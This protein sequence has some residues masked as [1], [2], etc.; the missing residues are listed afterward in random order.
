MLKVGI[1]YPT[2]KNEGKIRFELDKEVED[3]ITKDDR[4]TILEINEDKIVIE[5]DIKDATINSEFK[6]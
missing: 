6:L 2:M 4:I 3:I 5:V 1:S